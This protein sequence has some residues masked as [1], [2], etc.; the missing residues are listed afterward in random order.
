MST[1]ASWCEPYANLI[2]ALPVWREMQ[3]WGSSIIVMC[4]MPSN[5]T[6]QYWQSI[7]IICLQD[8]VILMSI[9]DSYGRYTNYVHYNENSFLTCENYTVIV[10]TGTMLILP[11]NTV[12]HMTSWY[13]E[14]FTVL[15]LFLSV[16]VQ[17]R[18]L[19]P[20]GSVGTLPRKQ[21]FCCKIT[22]ST[23]HWH[24]IPS[25][26]GRDERSAALVT[27]LF[28]RLVTCKFHKWERGSKIEGLPLGSGRFI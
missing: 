15:I 20:T 8:V 11:K 12:W 18:C 16:F 10:N 14:S 26:N 1:I 19:R 13:G 21:A 4:K 28:S 9:W 2:Y 22:S 27:C 23:R 24:W 6:T 3:T 7:Y 5:I 25:D 17:P